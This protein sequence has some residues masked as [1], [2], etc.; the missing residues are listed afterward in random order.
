MQFQPSASQSSRHLNS[1]AIIRLDEI[2]TYED[3]NDAS[4]IE[5]R[6]DF[7]LPICSSLNIAVK[8]SGDVSDPAKWSQMAH[9]LPPQVIIFGRIA[10]KNLDNR[11]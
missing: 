2:C 4:G 11:C 5:T 1:V 7:V 10:D 3:Q 6:L 9:Q 8:P